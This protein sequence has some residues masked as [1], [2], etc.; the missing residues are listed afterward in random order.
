VTQH[1]L[2]GAAR[3]LVVTTDLLR[4]GFEVYRSACPHSSFDLIAYKAGFVIR[5]EVKGEGRAPANSPVGA[6]APQSKVDCRKFDVLA[7][8][9]G[10]NVRYL[11][12]AMHTFNEAS[13]ELVG[14]EVIDPSTR[15]DYLARRA[16]MLIPGGD[17]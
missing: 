12:S 9:E 5:I 10:N 6:C 13:A 4:R 17:L 2:E 14:E 8:V 16:T 3:E 7:A 11:R 15:K 1:Q